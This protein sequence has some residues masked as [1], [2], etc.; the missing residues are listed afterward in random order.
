MIQVQLKLRPTRAQSRTF[1]RW[2]WHLTAVWN[3]T[4]HRQPLLRDV[5]PVDGQDGMP[6][7]RC[8]NQESD[9]STGRSGGRIV[10]E[11]ESC[12]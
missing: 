4:T 3:W 10:S 8:A 12:V 2:L 6:G 9:R 1:D 5:R 11:R 7:V